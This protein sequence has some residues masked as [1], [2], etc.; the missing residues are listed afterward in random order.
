MPDGIHGFRVYGYILGNF[1]K[2]VRLL[3]HYYHMV[4][5]ESWPGGWIR[6]WEVLYR[7][8]VVPYRPGGVL[9][10]SWIPHP[11]GQCLRALCM[12]AGSASPCS[13]PAT[14]RLCVGSFMPSDTA[15][16][17]SMMRTELYSC[18]SFL[19]VVGVV[20]VVACLFRIPDPICGRKYPSAWRK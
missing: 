9:T 1:G 15:P 6:T 14:H 17:F 20:P 13:S 18:R 16:S 19:Q 12:R 5:G 3:Y 10:S 2:L 7:T 4:A 11:P 8:M